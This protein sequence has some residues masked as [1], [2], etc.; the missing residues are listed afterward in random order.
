[1]RL[2]T[3]KVFGVGIIVGDYKWLDIFGDVDGWDLQHVR[4]VKWI[5]TYDDP[6]RF[7]TYTL[8]QGET[9]QKLNHDT[10]KDLIEWLQNLDVIQ[11]KEYEEPE[12]LPDNSYIRNIGTEEISEFL[13]EH[14]VDSNSINTLIEE[15]D[16]LIRIAKWYKKKDKGPSE[17]ETVTYLVVPL[18]RALG[19]TPQKMGIEW[20]NID[21]A[22]FC[23]L[24]RAG[25]NLDVVVEAKK[26][27]NSCLTAKSQAESYAIDRKNCHR[28]ILTD[29]LRYGIFLRNNDSFK[30]HS[31]LNLTNLKNCYPIYDCMGARE[32]LLA[33]TP[34][35]RASKI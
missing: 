16:E 9:T 17:H 35:Y 1:L 21:L 8:K 33:M 20:K 7:D 15:I 25:E 29:G 18:L 31:Y 23:S 2:G 28:V 27:G 5:K 26:K 22:L 14:G 32:S 34:E 12:K 10:S 6:K 30:L 3:K 13:F 4:R 24:P 11:E 19:W